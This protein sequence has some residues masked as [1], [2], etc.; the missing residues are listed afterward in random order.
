MK[1]YLRLLLV[2]ML[3]MFSLLPAVG[4]WK[5]S[6][7]T[8]GCCDIGFCIE[9]TECNPVSCQCE[10]TTFE[11]CQAYPWK[12]ECRLAQQANHQAK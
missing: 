6:A 3:V 7:R 9:L 4:S 8:S 11:C 2:V 12:D 10:C 1:N 5:V